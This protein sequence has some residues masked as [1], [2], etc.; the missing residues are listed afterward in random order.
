[1]QKDIEERKKLLDSGELEGNIYTIRPLADPF[2]LPQKAV[3][4]KY[5]SED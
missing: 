2:S 3:T 4:G 1:L 5:R